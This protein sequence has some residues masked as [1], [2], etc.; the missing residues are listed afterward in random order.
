MEK[1]LKQIYEENIKRQSTN[2]K[3]LTPEEWFF[4]KFKDLDMDNE[5]EVK[6]LALN[7]KKWAKWN[8][9]KAIIEVHES[10]EF[11]NTIVVIHN[12]FGDVKI[13]DSWEFIDDVVYVLEQYGD[14]DES[15]FYMVDFWIN[16]VKI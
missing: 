9:G 3:S 10:F 12:L 8:K 6:K 13:E 4:N 14:T 16:E 5:F 7:F 15:F 11:C 2:L 1:I